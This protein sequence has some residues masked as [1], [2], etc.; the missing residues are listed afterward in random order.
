MYVSSERNIAV[1]VW[2]CVIMGCIVGRRIPPW[3]T[4]STTRLACSKTVCSAKLCT[5]TVSGRKIE[6]LRV[7]RLTLVAS[8]DGRPRVPAGQHEC[9]GVR[10]R[11][12]RRD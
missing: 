4:G 6:A 8:V 12:E 1:V 11:C 7:L 2:W 10:R 9:R 5:P 3:L